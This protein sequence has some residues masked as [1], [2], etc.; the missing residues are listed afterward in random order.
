MRHDP[1]VIFGSPRGGTSLV[2]GCFYNHGFWTGEWFGGPNGGQGYANYE[3]K[4]LKKFI[5]DNFKLDAGKMME[6]PERA[7]V[8][9]FMEKQVPANAL[10]MWK[11][12]VEYYPIFAHWFPH[13]VP[14]FVFRKEEQAIEAVVR[15]RGEKER[16]GAEKIIR[17]RYDTM[18]DL[19]HSLNF[20]FAV[21]ADRVVEGDY[22][23]IERVLK[24]YGIDCNP[25]ACGKHI[26]PSKWHV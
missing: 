8:A 21:E 24:Y 17:A 23:Q 18:S 16:A 9:A 26:D 20:A 19:V 3:N 22:S 15:R 12:P 11:G 25:E 5:K 14:V 7:D 2:A 6:L 1:I 10:W 13:M 4:H